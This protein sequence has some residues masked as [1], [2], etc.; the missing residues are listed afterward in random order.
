V[1]QTL[2]YVKVWGVVTLSRYRFVARNSWQPMPPG[3]K[4]SVR[5]RSVDGFDAYRWIEFGN[6]DIENAQLLAVT[7]ISVAQCNPPYQ[8]LLR[9]QQLLV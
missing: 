2:S 8:R 5:R 6:G 7:R 1:S 4:N 9:A 3:N